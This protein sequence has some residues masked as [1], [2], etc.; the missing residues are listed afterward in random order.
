MAQILAAN[1]GGL[2]LQLNPLLIAPEEM[3]KCVNVDSYSFGA[4]KKRAGYNTFLATADTSQVNSLFSWTKNDGTTLN[5]YRASGTK[6]YYS[7]QGTAAWAVC[8]NGTIASGAHVDY[9][10]SANTLFICDGAG[11]TRHSTNG[12]SF[13]DTTLA[14]VAVSLEEYQGRVYAAGTASHT[15]YSTSGT[16]TDWSTDSS[17]V[18]MPG[19]GKLSKIFKA[20]DRLVTIK[21][22]GLMHRWDGYSLLDL[23]TNL[24]YTSPY[25]MGQSEGYYFGLNKLGIQG[26][27][28]ARMKIL[29]NKIQ[30][31]IYNDAGNGIAGTT[32]DNAAG[33]VNKYDYFLSIG[34]VTDDLT[35]SQIAD[36]I[37]KY[38]FQLNEFYTYKFA[39]FPTAWHSYEDTSGNQQL[40]FGNASGQCYKLSGTATSDNG[41]AIESEMIYVFHGGS[42]ID[43]KFNWIRALF[44]PGCQAKIAVSVTDTFIAGSKK[45]TDLGSVNSG[46]LEVRF[47][48]EVSRGKLLFIKI[49]EAST[50]TRFEFYGYELDYDYIPE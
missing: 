45:W 50:Q 9:T 2:N 23:S 40:I 8:G 11:S 42:F 1:L 22:S 6:L 39:H 10:I 47:P 37:L 33:A 14:P 17:S 12:T 36:A 24:G 43:K 44:N 15:F 48:P 41:T 29:S 38:N 16:P 4:K 19:A 18:E 21:N 31:L 13:T 20:A 30:K 26:F 34:T 27:E 5:L 28:G 25:S 35:N 46:V 7:A 49:Y 3:I 32:F